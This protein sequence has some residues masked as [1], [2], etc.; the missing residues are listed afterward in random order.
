MK[1]DAIVVASGEGKRANLGF[2]KTMYVMRNGKTVVE[3]ACQLFFEDEDCSR[4]IVVSNDKLKFNNP[5]MIVV[6]GG[7]ERCNSVANGLVEVKEEYV[8]IH[9]GVRPFL[10]RKDLENLKM[11]IKDCDGAILAIKAINT[12]KY[13]ENGIIVKSIDREKTYSAQTPQAF[14]TKLLR[15]AYE[16]ID[17]KTFTDEATAFEEAGLQ[18][19]VVQGD[20]SNIKLTYKED[21]LLI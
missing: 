11:A 4:V 10:K 20:I 2:N 9:D 19:K 8:L 21:F 17:V 1:Y 12:I 3:N 16:A 6:G 15:K 5:K 18:V 13:V 7:E 14:N